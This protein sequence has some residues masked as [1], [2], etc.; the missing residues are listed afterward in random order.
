MCVANKDARL[1]VINYKLIHWRTQS[2]SKCSVVVLLSI[3]TLTY[4]AVIAYTQ[5]GT[6]AIETGATGR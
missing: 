6:T 4:P 5:K 3:F 1:D 2:H